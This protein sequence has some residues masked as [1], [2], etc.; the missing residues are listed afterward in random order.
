[1]CFALAIPSALFGETYTSLRKCIAELSLHGPISRDV[2]NMRPHAEGGNCMDVIHDTDSNFRACGHSPR[3]MSLARFQPINPSRRRFMHTYVFIQ[4][5]IMLHDFL[6]PTR[7]CPNAHHLMLHMASRVITQA[8][9]SACNLCIVISL[10]SN[11][12]A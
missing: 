7:L 2:H 8:S 6:F 1:M 11:E 4:Q 9:A 10:A 3:G 5:I 12:C